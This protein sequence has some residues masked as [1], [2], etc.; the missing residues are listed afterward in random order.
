M[1][2]LIK[3]IGLALKTADA[4]KSITSLIAKG[5]PTADELDKLIQKHLDAN[6]RRRYRRKL[7]LIRAGVE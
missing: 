7:A 4:A 6:A 3:I 5:G 1:S 2:E